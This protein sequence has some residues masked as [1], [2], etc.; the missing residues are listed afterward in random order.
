M[1]KTSG[2]AYKAWDTRR[3]REA[4][5]KAWK[6]MW[7]RESQMSDVELDRLHQKRVRAARKAWKTIRAK[8]V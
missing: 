6:T 8:A 2:A 4:A 7:K 5:R 1:T 3:H